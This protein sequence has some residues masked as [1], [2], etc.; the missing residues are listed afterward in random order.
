[1]VRFL[2]VLGLLPNL[3][4][5]IFSYLFNL[6]CH[7]AF[8]GEAALASF[9]GL[10][11]G[12][13]S[14]AVFLALLLAGRAYRRMGLSA[15]SLVQPAAFGLVFAG[16]G[17]SASLPVAAA[18]Q[19]LLR[20]A[21]Q[22]IAGPVNKVLFGLVPEEA[23]AWCRVFVRGTVV[24]RGWCWAPWSCCPWARRPPGPGGGGPGLLLWWLAETWRFHRR[25]RA[26]LKQVI[27][28]GLPDYDRLQP[29]SPGYHLAPRG[30]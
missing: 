28:A 13:L 14:L 10:F 29:V 17:L 15:A 8:A 1:M 9:L 27:A 30:T 24:K 18:G 22:A 12:A 23:A 21:Q 2:L 25:Y 7:D 20:L 6:I 11:R 5:P 3:L 4:L 26:S 19:F 16:L